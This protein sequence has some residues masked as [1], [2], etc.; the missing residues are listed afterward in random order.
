MDDFFVHVLLFRLLCLRFTCGA[1]FVT[2]VILQCTLNLLYYFH[3]IYSGLKSVAIE[4]RIA[5]RFEKSLSLAHKGKTRRYPS[6]KEFFSICSLNSSLSL[7]KDA[8][9]NKGV[10]LQR[11]ERD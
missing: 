1:A 5:V 6:I 11:R 9:F 7:G 8:V 2:C 4:S 3:I 10:S